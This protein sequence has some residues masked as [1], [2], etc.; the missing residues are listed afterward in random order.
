[1]NQPRIQKWDQRFLN[2]AKEI[3]SW[4][5]DPSTKVGCIIIKNVNEIVSLGYNGFPANDP[6][7]ESEYI[8]RDIKYGKIIHAEINAVRHAISNGHW[9]LKG[10]TI[11]TY[12]FMPCEDCA[13]VLIELN[14]DRIVSISANCEHLSRWKDSFEK[15]RKLFEQNQI[16][17]VTL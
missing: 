13:K 14:P 8:N 17:V 16:E 5:K 15:S 3:S 11:Y 2:L 4:S 9:G 12:P 7:L 1:M 10:C 6:D